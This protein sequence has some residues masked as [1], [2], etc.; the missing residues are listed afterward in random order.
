[1]S[2]PTTEEVRAA[3]ERIKP[4]VLLTPLLRAEGLDRPGY[5]VFLKPECLQRTGSFKV[6]GAW[7]ALL[8]L[9]AQTRERGVVTHSS[10]NHGQAMALAA[11]EAGMM[12]RKQPYPC[13]V[14][15][16]K[17]A[18]PS[19]V[20]KVKA[21][22]AEVLLVGDASEERRAKAQAL[23]AERGAT[24]IPSFDHP[25]VMAGQGSLGLE[26]MDQWMG[27]PSRTRRLALVAGPVGGG[28]LMGGTGLALRSRGFSNRIIGV[29]PE[30]ADDMRQSLAAGK[31]VAIPPP[32]TICDGLRSQTPG[33]LT[34]AAFQQAKLEMVAVSEDQVRRACYRLLEAQKLLVE[35][36]GAV[37]V[38]AW[39]GGAIAVEPD[40][41]P[42]KAGDAVLILSGGNVAPATVAAWRA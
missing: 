11:R 13:A 3:R 9:D 14:V 17:S 22:G 42:E 24:L 32:Q 5:R 6:R 25:Q 10:G 7:N 30:T 2:L 36:S 16:P 38:A 35:P 39:L 28:G 18:E 41:P 19:K 34:F 21:L 8:A 33:E 31:R 15:M 26:I 4:F 20:E 23:A 12:D 40:P 27:Q 37:A 1:M 29:E